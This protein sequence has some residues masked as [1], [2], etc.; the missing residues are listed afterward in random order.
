MN[1]KYLIN[2][3]IVDYLNEAF[4]DDINPNL[5]GIKPN[6]HW[7]DTDDPIKLYDTELDDIITGTSSNA[8]N[9]MKK[10]FLN[11]KH[12]MIVNKMPEKTFDLLCEEDIIYSPNYMWHHYRIK[13]KGI[14]CV[15]VYRWVKIQYKNI[16]KK[17]KKL[18]DN[19]ILNNKPV[20]HIFK[21]DEIK[22]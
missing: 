7:T 17:N 10:G 2:K 12:F 8:K 20:V 18:I 3:I 9:S 4:R 16:Y 6:L 14:L 21:G 15:I 22:K 13:E 11:K 5:I 1:L 19:L